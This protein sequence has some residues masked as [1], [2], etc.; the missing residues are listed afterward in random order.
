MDFRGFAENAVSQPAHEGC[1][2]SGLRGPQ[3]AAPAPRL[4]ICEVQ[5]GETDGEG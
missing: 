2:S 5:K 4:V 1:G 3:A